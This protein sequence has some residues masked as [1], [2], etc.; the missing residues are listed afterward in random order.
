MSDKENFLR[1]VNQAFVEGDREFLLEAIS[2]DI[3]WD[4][5]GEKMVSG[6]NE[7]S[8]AL[9]QM[10]EMPPIKIDIHKVV[11]QEASAVVT[12]V[13]VGRNHVGQKKNF[14]FCD[15]YELAA[16]SKELRINKM[17]SY[18]IDISKYKQYRETC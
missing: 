5:V 2:E 18:V 14:G 6:K 17:T 1:K 8:D 9:E 7:F 16:D 10:Q 13:V 15:I 11:I 12:G 4:I 3:C